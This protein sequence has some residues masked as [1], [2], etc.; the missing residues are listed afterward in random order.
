MVCFPGWNFAQTDGTSTLQQRPHNGSHTA[1]HPTQP[2]KPTRLGREPRHQPEDRGQVAQAP[3]ALL[4]QYGPVDE[5]RYAYD[6]N[7]LRNVQDAVRTTQLPRL[8]GYNG[9]PTLLAGGFQE[10]GVRLGTEY[11]YDNNGSMTQDKN[12]GITAIV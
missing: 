3:G 6:G 5:L 10:A 8:T 12:K 4:A 11:Y 1:R 9:A 7:R 2:G